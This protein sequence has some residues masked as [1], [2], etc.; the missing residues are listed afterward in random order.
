MNS[1]AYLR[2]FCRPIPALERHLVLHNERCVGEAEAVF[3][4]DESGYMM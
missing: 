1:V 2:L 4:G 3:H